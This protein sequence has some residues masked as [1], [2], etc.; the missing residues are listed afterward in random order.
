MATACFG[1]I[2]NA[3]TGTLSASSETASLGA[4]QLQNDQGN[5][6]SAWQT[7]GGV[8]SA[9]LTV[10]AGVPGA[11]WRAFGL[12]RTNLTG[13][14][15]VRWRVGAVA[16]MTSGVVFDT[17][18][19]AAGVAA[20]F[21]QSVLVAAAA[22]AGRYC[23]LDVADPGNPD[24]VLNVPLI[25]AGPV[26]QPA[27]NISAESAFGRD[28]STDEVVTRGGQEY[29]T[30][31]FVRRRWEIALARVRAAEVWPFA[32]ELDRVA[33]LGTNVLFVPDPASADRNREAVFGRLR[34]TSDLGHPHGVADARGWRCRVTE[35][36]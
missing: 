5:A 35:R 20:G 3:G 31:R 21:G 11:A 24:G 13:A 2:N 32:M 14:A 34:A 16:A 17:G 36:L 33:R 6:A 10:D 12:F 19:V 7:A 23:R 9:G 18:T 30:S 26:W 15:T 4:A 28:D 27:S 22:V 29:P 1:W 25:F 8:T